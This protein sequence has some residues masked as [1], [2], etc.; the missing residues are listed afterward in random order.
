MIELVA[1]PLT[2]MVLPAEKGAQAIV[3][4]LLVAGANIDA[5]DENKVSSATDKV[6][7]AGTDGGTQC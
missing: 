6:S 5:H 1:A 3:T 4:E 7:S 2:A